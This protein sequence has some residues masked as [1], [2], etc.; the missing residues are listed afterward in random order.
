MKKIKLLPTICLEHAIQNQYIKAYAEVEK[1]M[2]QIKNNKISCFNILINNKFLTVDGINSLFD[3]SSGSIKIPMYEWIIISDDNPLKQLWLV[4]KD[5]SLC[6][7]MYD[8]ENILLR[9]SGIYYY[10]LSQ[11]IHDENTREDITTKDMIYE[12]LS[13]TMEF[14]S[15]S[16]IAITLEIIY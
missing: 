15:K 8:N 2:F 1:Q 14:F 7:S 16:L 5:S 4:R 10:F 9:G 13:N 6:Y 12:W 11:R 3:L